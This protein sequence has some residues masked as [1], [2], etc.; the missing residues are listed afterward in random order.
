MK[1]DA[2]K[3]ELLEWVANLKDGETLQYLKELKDSK[4]LHNDWAEQLTAEQL[5][6]IKRGLQQVNNKEI[7][8]HNLVAQKH[9]L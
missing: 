6:S 8:P 9:G 3:V 2:I 4:Q 1:Y 7:V 5:K